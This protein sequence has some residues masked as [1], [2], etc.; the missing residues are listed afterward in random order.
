MDA[1]V[2]ARARRA[3]PL[4]SGVALT[5]AFPPLG[6]WPLAWLAL[7]PWYVAL[8]TPRGMRASLLSG[9]SFGLALFLIGMVWMNEIGTLPWIVLSLIQAVPFALLGATCG[10]LLPRLPAAA[11]PWAF[12]ALWTLLEG[13]RAWGRY[14]F[15]WFPLAATQVR[16]PAMVQI[17]SVTGQWGLSFALAAAGGLLGEA[18]LGWRNGKLGAAV[19]CASAAL[20]LSA[21]LATAGALAMGGGPE[22]PVLRV[23]V[24]QGNVQKPGGPIREEDLTEALRRYLD[25]TREAAEEAG[26]APAFIA[27]PETVVPR[28]LLGDSF[29]LAAVSSLARELRTPLLVGTVHLEGAAGRWNSAVLIDPDGGVRGRYDKV[30]LVPFGEFFPLRS[31]LKPFFDRYGAPS[32]DFV[33][34]KAPGVLAAGDGAP[35][36]GVLICYESAFGKLSRAA[37]R[38]GADV[39]ALLTSDQTFGRTA[40]P[41]QHADLCVLRAA[42]TRRW[43]VRAAS[44]GISEIVDPWG[45]VEESLGLN[46][47]DVIVGDIRP[48]HDQSLY[49]RWGDWFLGACALLVAGLLALCKKPHTTT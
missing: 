47:Q 9:F 45:R 24:A 48:R 38:R 11:R 7:S 13:L 35:K 16:V 2:A 20:L 34:G 32:R 17:V 10:W 12:A 5:L 25:L 22:G 26:E 40:G 27:W 1:V 3:A 42:E 4:L 43:L 14:S 6:W 31:L 41:A 28:P 19:R 8:A 29:T 18:W 44:T 30:Q 49:V 37:V 21:A 23:G 36:I 39:L 46:R 15:P 33:A